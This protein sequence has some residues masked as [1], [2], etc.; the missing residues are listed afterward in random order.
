MRLPF[1]FCRNWP[2]GKALAAVICAGAL[3]GCASSGSDES[4]LGLITPYRMEVVQGNVV[5]AE[6]AAM[7]KPGMTRAQVRDVLGSPMLTDVF[8]ADR[9]DY[10]FT[11]YRQGARPQRR[12]VVVRFD[13]DKLLRMDAPV[14]PVEREFVSSIDVFKA[15][16]NAPSLALTPDQIK[17]LPLP[18]KPAQQE[19]KPKAPLRNYPPLEPQG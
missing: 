12:H 11:I 14:L 13:G 18:S 5:T 6:Q 10:V 4:L 8:H 9:W 2:Q 3:A 15:P 1:C 19:P 17:E 16:R 7:I